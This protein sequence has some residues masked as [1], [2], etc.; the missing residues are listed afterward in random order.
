VVRQAVTGGGRLLVVQ[1]NN[2][3]YEQ[4]GNSGNG[5][6]TAQQLAIARLRAVEH[7]RAVV[8]AATSGVSAM[9]APNG[10]VLARTGVFT[11]AYL[12]MRLPLRD[13]LTLAD[14]VGQWPEWVLSVAALLALVMAWVRRR[15]D[16]PTDDLDVNSRVA[17]SEPV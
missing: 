17:I 11:P 10:K 12:D 2:A 6:E 15:P 5:G 13:P 4:Q 16:Q 1:T 9:I 3:S 8:V 14:R 7:G